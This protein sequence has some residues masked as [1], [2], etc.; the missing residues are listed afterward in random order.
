MD[1]ALACSSASTESVQCTENTCKET[2]RAGA[3]RRG[4]VHWL[5]EQF[6]EITRPLQHFVSNE[7]ASHLQR[8]EIKIELNAES[9]RIYS[10]HL[11]FDD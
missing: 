8:G 3:D 9:V 2:W 4:N 5:F 11:E 6:D 10:K 1:P 7:V